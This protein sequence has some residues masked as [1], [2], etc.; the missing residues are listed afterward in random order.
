MA[1]RKKTVV[2]MPWSA[3]DVMLVGCGCFA[4][5][6]STLAANRVIFGSSPK[7]TPCSATVRLSGP[8]FLVE[9]N[10]GPLTLLKGCMLAVVPTGLRL[11]V[12]VPAN[13]A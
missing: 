6:T 7:L 11:C 10:M 4:V 1:Y 13:E 5:A 3:R 12:R 8:R 2:T 9:P